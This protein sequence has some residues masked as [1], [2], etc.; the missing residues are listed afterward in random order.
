MVSWGV[1]RSFPKRRPRQAFTLLELLVVLGVISVLVVLSVP[2]LSGMGRAQALSKATQQLKGQFAIA[3]QLAQTKNQTVE[4]RFYLDG[5]TEVDSP[6]VLVASQVVAVSDDGT[7]YQ[8]E[9]PVEPLPDQV[10]ALTSG[11]FST[12]LTRAPT[13][14]VTGINATWRTPSKRFAFVE[15]RGNSTSNLPAPTAGQQ[16][17]TLTLVNRQEAKATS[18]P[19]NFATLLFRPMT[20]LVKVVRPE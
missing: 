18:L 19:A 13:A 6:L 3:R 8:P 12:L 10:A 9:T 16:A 11:T 15:F 14:S 2:M 20:G 1:Q 17:W 7:S 5:G 4:L